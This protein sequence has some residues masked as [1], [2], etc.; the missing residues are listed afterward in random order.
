[1]NMELIQPFINSLDAVIS[2]MMRCS[3]RIADV[4][5]EDGVLK[6]VSP[7]DDTPAARTEI[8]T[9]DFIIKIDGE[10]VEGMA[11]DQAVG[12]LRGAIHS[13]TTLTVMRKGNDKPFDVHLVGLGIVADPA[14][15]LRIDRDHVRH[16]A[17]APGCGP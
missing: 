6:V 14:H 7:I 5:M 11:L 4:T 13:S 12:K 17:L 16:R 2:E 9:N 15:H 10:D 1:M 8:L 3:A